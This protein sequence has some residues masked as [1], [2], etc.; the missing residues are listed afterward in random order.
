M[1]LV[2]KIHRAERFGAEFL[3][4]LWF[5]SEDDPVLPIDP[6][7]GEVEVYFEERLV[8]GSTEVN[9]QENFFKGGQP[10]TSAEARAALRLGK[11]AYEAKLRIIRGAQ[12]WSFV[13]KAR[14][15]G[16]SS[17]RIPAV[18]AKESDERFAER[19]ML[20][21]QLEHMLEA[22]VGRFLRLR[23]SDT[24]TAE[25]LPSIRRWVGGSSR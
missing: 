24:W 15:F 9:A 7:F 22:L 10:T 18:L 2:D 16:I 14:P 12:E 23:L 20:L 13:L 21:E 5:A 19:M 8:V 4:W 25:Q 1:D 17:V 11:Q 6:T 3:T